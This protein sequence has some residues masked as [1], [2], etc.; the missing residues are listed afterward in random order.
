MKHTKGKWE[1]LRDTNSSD[2]T[3]PLNSIHCQGRYICTILVT[4]SIYPTALAEAQANAK[5]ISKSPEMYEALKDE[6]LFL[7]EIFAFQS[8]TIKNDI[9]IRKSRINQLLKEIDNEINARTIN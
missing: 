6:L 9:S 5:L 7:D 2:F 8:P 3:V 4:R 1:Q